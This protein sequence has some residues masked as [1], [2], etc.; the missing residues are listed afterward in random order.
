MLLF[1]LVFDILSDMINNRAIDDHPEENISEI[2][3]FCTY[4]TKF[5]CS[6]ILHIAQ[7][8][9]LYDAIK[10]I[11]YIYYHPHKFDRITI[12]VVICLLKLFVE[13]GAEVI[14]LILTASFKNVQNVVINFISML[15]IS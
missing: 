7:Q 8:P 13:L 10:R 11:E 14:S 12:P 1:F 9:K 3:L 4:V 15:C 6:V 2:K 5:L